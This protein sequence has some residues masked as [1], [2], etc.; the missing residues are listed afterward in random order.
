MSNVQCFQPIADYNSRRLILG[1]MPGQASLNAREYYAHPRN[2]FWR[3]IAE[4][5]DCGFLEDYPSKIRALLNAH[6]ALWDVMKS[7]YRPGSLDTAIDK[8]SIIPNDF[9]SFF[10][11]HPLITQVYFNGAAAEQVFRQRVLPDLSVRHLEL[12]RLPSTSAAH[13]TLTYQQKLAC[14]RMLGHS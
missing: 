12:V 4:L 3:I 6:I 14:W 1:S 10:N 5:L 7:C 13:A 11:D 9:P 8:Q 2:Q